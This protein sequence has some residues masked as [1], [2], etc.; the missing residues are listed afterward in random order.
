MGVAARLSERLEEVV[1]RG[2]GEAEGSGVREAVGAGEKRVGCKNSQAV[3]VALREGLL[4]GE[5][6]PQGEKL[7]DSKGMLTV[8]EAEELLNKKVVCEL[9]DEALAELL[10][11][12]DALP[13]AL[14]VASTLLDPLPVAEALFVALPIAKLSAAQLPVA[15][16]VAE[17]VAVGGARTPPTLNPSEAE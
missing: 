7:S 9:V 4:V 17:G 10:A 1:G 14:P 2:E 13:V 11:V 15:V 16:A 12:E 6:V 5:A 3:K 8:A